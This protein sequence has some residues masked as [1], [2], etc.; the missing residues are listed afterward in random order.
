MFRVALI[1]ALMPLSPVTKQPNS[2]FSKLLEGKERRA[3]S[4]IRV[5]WN[6]LIVEGVS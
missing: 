6:R 1:A 3:R 5:G 4:G 2:G